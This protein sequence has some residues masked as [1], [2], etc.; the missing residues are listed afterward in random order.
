[1]VQRRKQP[2]RKMGKPKQRVPTNKALNKKIKNIENNLIE[3]KFN[4]F[5]AASTQLTTAYS[6]SSAAVLMASGAAEEQRDGNIINPTSLLIR[7]KYLSDVNSLSSQSIRWLV[8]WDRQP[9]GAVPTIMGATGVLD[10]TLI[11]DGMLA[12]HNFD[13][14]KRFKIIYD[15]VHTFNQYGQRI[16]SITNNTS[17]TA[18]DTATQLI[19]MSKYVSKYFKLNRQVKYSDNGATIASVVTNSLIMAWVTDATS[20]GPFIEFGARLYYRDS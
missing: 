10:N 11:T 3:L 14:N 17:A 16:S 4:D 12:P 5:N 13:T 20:N 6:L 2:R 8:F 15:K 7:M 9:N 18:T 1:M 19:Q